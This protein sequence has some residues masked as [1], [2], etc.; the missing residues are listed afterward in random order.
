MADQP[1]IAILDYGIGNLHSAHKGF[2]HA[3]ADAR[4]TADRGLIAEAAGVVLPGVGAFR[5]C[6]EA[7]QASGLDEV[8]LEV[9]GRGTPFF[10]ICIGMQLLCAGS[11]ESPGCAGL[12]VF[13]QTVVR[14]PDGVKHP[15]MQWN[16]LDRRAPEHPMFAGQ[17]AEA[18]MYFVH[19]FAA[20]DGPDVVATCDYGGPLVAA[21]ARDDLWAVQFHPEKSGENGLRMLESFV[22]LAGDRAGVVA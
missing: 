1:L 14:L 9:I 18:W 22:T 3:G 2:D 21:V 20:E 13:E 7:L 11:E 8:A 16:V 10:G 19:S 15:Q 12:G 4:L 17:P 5:P 6:M